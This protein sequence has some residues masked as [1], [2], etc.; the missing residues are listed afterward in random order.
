VRE[1]IGIGGPYLSEWEKVNDVA[2]VVL[3]QVV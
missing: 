3:V 2:D 1:G